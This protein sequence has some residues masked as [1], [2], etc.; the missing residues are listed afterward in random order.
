MNECLCSSCRNLKSRIN[1]D[2][3]DVIFEC[4]Y[5]Y[6]DESCE[7]CDKE[8]CRADCSHYMPDNEI[9]EVR[10]VKCIICG[11]ELKKAYEDNEEGATYCFDCY[12][13]KS[14]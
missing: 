4:E 6:P 8:Q 3:G 5:G 10:I 1:K 7:T 11:K 12:L 14:Y 9:D 13:N 2:E